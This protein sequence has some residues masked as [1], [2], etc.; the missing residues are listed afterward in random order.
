MDKYNLNTNTFNKLATQY[1]D[2]FMN[3]DGY[4]DTFDLFINAIDKDEAKILEIACGPG[5]VTKYLH[6]H[7]PNFMIYGIDVA[8][9][10]IELARTNNP[11]A[12]YDVMDCR[13]LSHFNES[14]DAIMCAFGLPYITQ[15]DAIKLINDSCGLLSENGVLYISTM[16]GKYSDSEYLKSAAYNEGTYV[17]YH[18]AA[19]LKET[20]E[21]NNMKVLHEVRKPYQN[22]EGNKFVDLFL[23]AERV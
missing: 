3:Y 7:K 20:L 17:Y 6:S 10:M 13:Y 22:A 12:K 2:R 18:E 23:I 8:P 16:E 4:L 9:K 21:S 11:A 14:F 5:Y 1:Q 19:Y 15:E